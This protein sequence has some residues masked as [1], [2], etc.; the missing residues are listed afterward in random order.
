MRTRVTAMLALAALT[1]SSWAGAGQVDFVYDDDREAVAVGAEVSGG[2]VFASIR[3]VARASG[4]RTNWLGDRHRLVV[5]SGDVQ[6][7][8]TAWNP[9]VLVDDIAYNLPSPTIMRGGTLLAP[10]A[11][12]ALL[13]DPISAGTLVWDAEGSAFTISTRQINV[14]PGMIEQRENGTVLRIQVPSELPVQEETNGQNWLH[15]TVLGGNIDAQ[16]FSRL[17]LTGAIQQILAYQY[18]N[19]ARLSL[20]IER[21][22]TY[23]MLRGNESDWIMMLFRR[24]E[25][26]PAPLSQV[27]ELIEID[28][29]QWSINTIV[30]DP[31]H[32][33]RDPGAVGAGGVL[34][35]GVVLG[36]ASRLARRLRDD[37]EV[38]VV[39]TRSDDR[40]VSL[41]ERGR[42]ATEAGGKLF[43]SIH[44][45]TNPDARIT[46]IETYFLSEALT[47]E[48]REVAR[49]ENAALRY[50]EPD[51]Q[52]RD[53]SQYAWYE[54]AD[55]DEILMGMAS[56]H[57]LTESQD[58]AKLVQEELVRSL[59]A[60]DLGVRQAE[61]YV[62]KGTLANMPS[63]LVEVGFISNPA[64]AR[65]MRQGAYQRRAA[66]AIY[67][68]I[69]EFKLR[70][71]SDL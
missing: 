55:V 33:G 5:L 63:I 70:Y 60:R 53:D 65:R 11:E 20:R 46:G 14:R 32:G 12:I 54:W 16:A 27:G 62:M 43:V 23:E 64:E 4:L 71:E 41:R 30:I 49:L 6:A 61:F 13:L 58:F 28:R 26:L 69:R 50:E 18:A 21:G 47:S 22:Y 31:G 68:A 1:M 34:E 66:D 17:G 57:F 48:A 67:R 52:V 39:M 37:L 36:I 40:A 8:F 15:L 24:E 7:K 9:I 56:S 35:K 44:A 38:E 10:A 19:S 45:N 59:G 25:A 3:D 29:N 51:E 2:I 42:I